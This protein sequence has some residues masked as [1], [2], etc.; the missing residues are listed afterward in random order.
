MVGE[1]V[2]TMVGEAMLMSMLCEA[3]S[4][5]VG[6]AMSMSMVGEAVSTMVG[7]AMSMSMVGEAVSTMVGEAMSMSMGDAESTAV[8]VDEPTTLGETNELM[9]TIDAGESM[10]IGE[11]DGESVDPDPVVPTVGAN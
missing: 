2:S 6:K 11:G 5:I 1:A 8:A 7:E 4:V 10:M 3:V 9:E